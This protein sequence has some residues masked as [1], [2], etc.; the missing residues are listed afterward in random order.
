LGKL[1][2][3]LIAKKIIIWGHKLHSHTSSYVHYGFY[4]AF[5]SLGFDTYWFDDNDDVS[6]FNFNNSI[7]LTEGQVDTKIPLNNTCKYILHSGNKDKYINLK[8]INIQ[9]FHNNINSDFIPRTHP[10]FTT[11]DELTK[12]NDYTYISSDTIYQPWATDLLPEEINDNE[13]KNEIN[14]RECVWVGTY[15]DRVTE[16]QNSIELDLFFDECRK[17]NINVRIIDPWKNPVSFEENRKIV[18]KSFLAPA[19]QG[20]WQVKHGYA[21]QCRV[22]KNISYGHMGI[23]NNEL[24]NNLFNNMLVCDPNPVNLFYK[25]IEKKNSL[26]IIDEIKYL[27]NEVKAKHT[28]VNRVNVILSVLENL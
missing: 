25:S 20:P 15:G 10:T 3:N 8:K 14:N 9:I 11:K 28:Y 12:I 2:V 26:K 21:P 24:T 16:Y 22:L 23:T 4:K 1:G 13:A 27:M 7:F 19:I 6:G 17:N 18:N 5:K